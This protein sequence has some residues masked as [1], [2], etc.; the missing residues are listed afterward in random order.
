MRALARKGK[1]VSKPQSDIIPI[2]LNGGRTLYF[3]QKREIVS[4][5]TQSKRIKLPPRVEQ[6]CKEI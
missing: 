3:D 5:T 1:N 6:A 2:H 4:I